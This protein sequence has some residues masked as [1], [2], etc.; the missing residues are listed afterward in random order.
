MYKGTHYYSIDLVPHVAT[1]IT[2]SVINEFGE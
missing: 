1:K 2:P